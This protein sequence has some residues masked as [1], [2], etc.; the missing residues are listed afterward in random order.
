MES[1]KMRITEYV[2]IK[3]KYCR[4]FTEEPTRCKDILSMDIEHPM[5]Y[6]EFIRVK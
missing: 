4:L 5:P 1:W 6:L 2:A 3:R